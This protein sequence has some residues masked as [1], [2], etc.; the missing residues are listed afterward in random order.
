MKAKKIIAG[1]LVATMLTGAVALNASAAETSDYVMSMYEHEDY[2]I[3]HYGY[4]HYKRDSTHM[5]QAYVA[6]DYFGNTSTPMVTGQSVYQVNTVTATRSDRV[7]MTRT[8]TSYAFSMSAVSHIGDTNMSS[9]PLV[10]TSS[11]VIETLKGEFEM[12]TYYSG[13]AT[14]PNSNEETIYKHTVVK[15]FDDAT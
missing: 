12:R 10:F 2:G 5:T 9:N 15:P 14:H 8:S 3:T 13:S 7:K 4:L 1:L 11:Q 6:S